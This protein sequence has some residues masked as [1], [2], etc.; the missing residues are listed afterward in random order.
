[1]TFWV[2]GAVAG[3]GLV[4][5]YFGNKA[6]K[7]AADKSAQATMASIAEQRRQY[8]TSRADQAPYLAAG[9]GAVN[10]LAA[11]VGY[12]GEF[13]ST[14]PFDFQYDQN[15]DP[16]TAFRM[17]EGI[18]AL[19][20]SAASRGGLLS[21]A[22]LKGVQ[23]YGSDLGSQEYNNAFNRYVT[24]FNAN[25]GERNALYNRLAG[26]AGTGQTATGQIGAQ[27]A[28]TASNIGASLMGSAANT[29]NAALAAAGIRNSAYGG[30]ANVLG[31]MYGGYGGGAS[32]SGGGGNNSYY[33]NTNNQDFF[34]TYAPSTY[35]R[36]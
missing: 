28:N 21:G 10:R 26:V 13:G 32:P 34:D 5:G 17:S 18:K 29:G 14:R 2:A 9:T 25:T 19:D 16:G 12:G 3:T 36:T 7:D 31:R 27:G 8:D 15:A 33:P 4:S 1:M 30:A 22:T 35:Q 20:R 23:R 11:G 24:G 6:A